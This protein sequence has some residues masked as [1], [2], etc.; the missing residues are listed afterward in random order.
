MIKC[1]ALLP[2]KSGIS[3]EQF[4]S[5]WRGIHAQLALRIPACDGTCRAIDC[6]D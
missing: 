4:H 1:F 5:H 3:D 2:K 6:L